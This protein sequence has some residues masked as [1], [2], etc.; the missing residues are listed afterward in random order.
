M[1]RSIV[2]AIVVVLLVAA[3]LIVVPRAGGSATAPS[4]SSGGF[5]D[6]IRFFE[7]P[8]Q[9]HALLDLK[10]GNMDMYTFPLRTAA[11]IAAAHSDPDLRTDDVYGQEDN[12]FVNPVPVDQTLAPGVF[13]PFE[14]RDVRNA[15]NYLIDREYIN[16]QLFGGYGTTHA[17]LWNNASPEVARDPFFFRDLNRDARYNIT[18]AHDLV[19]NALNASGAT[20]N[21]TW[22]WQGNPIV[23][24][25]VIRIED[26]RT[27]IGD[28]VANQVERLGLTVNRMYKTGA[29][30]FSI[31]YNGPPDTGAWMLYTEGWAPTQIQTWADSDPDF[32]YCGGE[33][34]NVWTVYAPRRT[35]RPHAQIS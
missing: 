30:A 5:V 11:D 32:F 15:L 3:S 28:Y 35:S 31:V 34:S 21:G 33:G 22:S 20:F 17:A 16:D 26:A 2:C 29:I 25:F 18:R 8:N 14:L 7:Q 24:N 13:N 6:S 27:R 12:L 1:R 9:A 10:N 23:V 19:F 4:P